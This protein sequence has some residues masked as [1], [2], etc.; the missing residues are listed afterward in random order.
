MLMHNMD[1]NAQRLSLDV[2][3][4]HASERSRNVISFELDNYNLF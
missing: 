4:Q 2:N 3:A 1:V